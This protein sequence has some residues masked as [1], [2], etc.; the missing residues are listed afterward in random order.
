MAYKELRKISYISTNTEATDLYTT[1]KHSTCYPTRPREQREATSCIPPLFYGFIYAIYF[2]QIKQNNPDNDST[3][4]SPYATLRATESHV[5]ILLV[6]ISSSLT[7]LKN[8]TSSMEAFISL[9][10]ISVPFILVS[11]SMT[12]SSSRTWSESKDRLNSDS[13]DTHIMGVSIFLGFS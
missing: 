6:Q 13:F 1:L 2:V 3:R 5:S 12:L 10:G 9:V 8:Y 11:L 4:Y 7:K